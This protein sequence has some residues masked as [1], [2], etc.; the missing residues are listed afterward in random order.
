MR[1]I[2]LQRC[3]TNRLR[4]GLTVTS[5]SHPFEKLVSDVHLLDGCL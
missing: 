3:E 4:E 2:M 5:R 1:L